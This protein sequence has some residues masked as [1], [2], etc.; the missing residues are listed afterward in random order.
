MGL[1]KILLVDD[2]ELVLPTLCEILE[3]NGFAKP[4]Q[5]T[6]QKL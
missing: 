3:Q 1:I 4:P 2:D 5:S 6:C